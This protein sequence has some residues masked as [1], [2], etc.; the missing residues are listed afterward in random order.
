MLTRRTFFRRAAGAVVG[1]LAAVYVPRLAP[2]KPLV[3]PHLDA[4]AEFMREIQQ[5]A[6]ADPPIHFREPLCGC[7]GGY[8]IP[9][10]VSA[11]IDRWF[12]VG[13]P[14]IRLPRHQCPTLTTSWRVTS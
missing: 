4:F 10:E 12:E 5:A 2:A 3:E 14:P 8:L 6:R 7:D 9:P 11:A 13:A 1:V